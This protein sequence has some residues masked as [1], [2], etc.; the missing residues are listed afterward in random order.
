SLLSIGLPVVVSEPLTTHEFEPMP[1]PSAP[2][3]LGRLCTALRSALSTGA[4]ARHTGVPTDGAGPASV[5]G[6]TWKASP[7]TDPFAMIG[8]FRAYGYG[9]YRS[10]IWLRVRPA[11][12]SAARF[13]SASMLLRISQAIALSQANV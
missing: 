2:S 5:A 7:A 13:A 8:R 10:A 12:S 11:A 6:F 9:G 4:A 1:V 3:R